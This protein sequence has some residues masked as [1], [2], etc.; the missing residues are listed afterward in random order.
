[1]L[2]SPSKQANGE[3]TKRKENSICRSNAIE[4]RD[5]SFLPLSSVHLS[6]LVLSP[7][8]LD[9]SLEPKCHVKG[10]NNADHAVDDRGVS[11]ET[12]IFK[13]RLET[14][15]GTLIDAAAILATAYVEHW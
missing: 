9:T 5:M 12:P 3:L 10:T 4:M 14:G 13:L 6:F 15:Q 2:R 11:E 7:A 1:M 8:S